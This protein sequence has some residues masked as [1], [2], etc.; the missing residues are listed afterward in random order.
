MGARLPRHPP[1]L[2]R[3]GPAADLER[4]WRPSSWQREA[5][6][7]EEGPQRGP[8]PSQRRGGLG[9]SQGLKPWALGSLS[10]LARAPA[11]D[12]LPQAKGGRKWLRMSSRVKYRSFPLSDGAQDPRTLLPVGRRGSLGAARALPN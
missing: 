3:P 1:P 8:G 5:L 11:Q 2:P 7:G 9:Q 6:P 12:R 10:G 4:P